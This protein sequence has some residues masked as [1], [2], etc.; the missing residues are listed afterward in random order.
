MS[1]ILNA[2]G[3]KIQYILANLLGLSEGASY[4]HICGIGKNSV[5]LRNI[6]GTEGIIILDWSHYQA[7]QRVGLVKQCAMEVLVI[8][9]LEKS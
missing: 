9:H 2:E 1:H 3:E 5:K 6:L 4:F 7:I 8:S